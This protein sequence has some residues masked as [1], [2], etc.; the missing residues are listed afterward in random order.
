MLIDNTKE[1]IVHTPNK[2]YVVS[3]GHAGIFYSRNVENAFIFPDLES[4]KMALTI[5]PKQSMTIQN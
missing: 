1:Y 2:G 5:L 3:I 4:A